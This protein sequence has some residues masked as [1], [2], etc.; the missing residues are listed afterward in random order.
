MRETIAKVYVEKGLVVLEMEGYAAIGR[1]GIDDDLSLVL[2][3]DD[4]QTL[5]VCRAPPDGEHINRSHILSRCERHNAVE[6]LNSFVNK[7]SFVLKLNYSENDKKKIKLNKFKI[8]DRLR[9][10]A[11]KILKVLK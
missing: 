5:L 8:D 2:S 10:D 11:K 4:D 3:V 1:R 6:I 9:A 7:G